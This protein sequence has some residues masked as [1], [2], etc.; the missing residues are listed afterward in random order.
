MLEG[1]HIIGDA[2][3][4]RFIF[5]CEGKGFVWAL[6]PRAAW[7][8]NGVDI[9]AMVD[10]EDPQLLG[11]ARAA[12]EV[13]A[14][15]FRGGAIDHGPTNP[16]LEV[17]QKDHES[18][19]RRPQV[20]QALRLGVGMVEGEVLSQGVFDLRVGGKVFACDAVASTT[21]EAFVGLALGL[22]I[23]E[24]IIGNQLRSRGSD[25]VSKAHGSP[26]CRSLQCTMHLHII[27]ICGTFMGGL[28]QIAKAMGHR[29]TGCDAH[30]YPPMSDQLRAAG[31]DLVE[32]FEVDQL[33]LRPDL[34]VVGNVARRGQPL[35]EA[36]LNGRFPMVSGPQWMSQ[37]LL[38]DRR[39]LAV[40]GTH[41]KTTTSSLAAWLLEHAGL[42]PG[43]LIGGVPED[44]GCSA[45]PGAQD[46][47]FVIEA[48]EY[49]TAFF[50]KRS[51]L[52][53]YRAEV[54][55][56]NNLEFD[57]ADIF[58]DLAA[59]ETQFHHWIRTLP[60][61]GHLVVNAEAPA[62][63]RVL[64]RGCWTPVTRFLDAAGW[65]IG[66]DVTAESG[67]EAFSILQDGRTVAQARS[68]LWGPHNRA[69]A[70]AALLAVQAC[71][72]PWPTLLE[73]LSSFQGVKRRMQVRGTS[74]GVTV[75]DDFAHHPTAIAT[76]LS[77]LRPQLKP[78][79]RLLA[80][81]EPRS[82]TMKMGVMRVKLAE[83][84]VGADL[85]FGFA[86]GLD[87]PLDEALAPLGS[88]ASSSP[89][90]EA[91]V[92]QVVSA[93]RPGDAILVMSNGGFGGIHERLLA[94]LSSRAG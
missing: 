1:A 2:N 14:G 25:F 21:G 11:A 40:S 63:A 24:P 7:P 69:N 67:F 47:W 26:L 64:E 75:Y 72:V 44:F 33:A 42:A 46:G 20:L 17:F 5:P 10:E 3:H 65:S 9:Q 87:W 8:F 19:A 71:G 30:V 57:H 91:L 55:I 80:V 62:I 48:D 89:D 49:D 94:E 78:G 41:G 51:K 12:N 81:L 22:L 70:L 83:S 53:H 73:G 37:H 52:L 76:T 58:P 35:V 66:S 59:I 68:P 45:R 92:A 61:Q 36:L 15:V 27:G 84:L 79:A 50:D 82:N 86:G 6:S 43:F 34:W 39:V 74:G 77:G 18:M 54:A 56:V 31:I 4:H 32:G 60:S 23:T 29:V 38:G 13:Q 28:A 93:A 90:F 16:W 88:R 85:V